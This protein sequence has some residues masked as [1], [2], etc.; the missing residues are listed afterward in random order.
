MKK[1]IFSLTVVLVLLININ[2]A[3]AEM[4]ITGQYLSSSECEDALGLGIYKLNNYAVGGYGNLQASLFRRSEPHYKSLNLNSFGDPVTSWFKDIFTINGGLTKKITKYIAVY[5]GIGYAYIDG[6]AE[7]YD[8]YH[9]LS[10]D[11]YYYVYDPSNSSDGLNMNAG[12]LISVEKLAIEIGYNT[13]V[14]NIYFGV[15]INF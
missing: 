14:E 12:L 3:N 1:L 13:F 2:I 5:A 4:V 11:G 8:P 10:P 9:I 7:K 6:I 15:G